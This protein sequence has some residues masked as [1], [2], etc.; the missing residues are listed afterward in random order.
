[1][2]LSSGEKY[3][4]ASQVVLV[5]EPA[6]A[7]DTEDPWVKQIPWKRAWQP[8]PVF[9]PGESQGWRSLVGYSPQG[10]N[11][12][13]LPILGL[14]CLFTYWFMWVLYIVRLLNLGYGKYLLSSGMPF[15]FTEVIFARQQS[16]T[17]NVLSFSF[18]VHAS[19]SS[20]R[21]H[22]FYMS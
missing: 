20:L 5:K 22:F 7:G 3:Y 21:N 13:N 9:L 10:T 15:H 2:S 11:S 18:I 4:W 17:L 6:H 1:M 8:T 16:I 12:V 19:L 14:N